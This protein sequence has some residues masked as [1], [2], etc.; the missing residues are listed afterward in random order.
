MSDS[1]I[2]AGK[3]LQIEFYQ[4]TDGEMPAKRYLESLPDRTQAKLL[5]LVRW[6]SDDGQIY[7]KEKFRI[8]NKRERIF[9]FKPYKYR[10]FS[11]FI[12]EG[13]LI[14]TNG[15]KKASQKVSKK[16]LKIAIQ[17]KKDYLS[18][19]AWRQP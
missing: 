11:F 5:A 14:I 16:D 9:E 3:K 6:I 7:D 12:E 18:R 10:F 2:H 19:F 13:K 15:Y 4:K 1:V 17:Y 8:V